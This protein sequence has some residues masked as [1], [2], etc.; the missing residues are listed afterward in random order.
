MTCLSKYK[1]FF[2]KPQEGVHQHR[3]LGTAIVD[4][5]LTIIGAMIV[6]YFSEIPLV[7][8]TII[9]L[10]LGVIFHILFGV[11]TVTTKYLGFH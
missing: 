1:D 5:L 2:G 9:L 8:T 7:L 3:F 6:T 11:S 10:I 4:Y